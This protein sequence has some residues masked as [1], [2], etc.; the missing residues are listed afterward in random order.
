MFSDYF[1]QLSNQLTDYLRLHPHWITFTFFISG[2]TSGL[3]LIGS[4]LPASVLHFTL[5]VLA[6]KLG[7]SLS[8][9]VVIMLLSVIPGDF[10]GYICGR[11]FKDKIKYCRLFKKRT[12]WF[13]RAE[14]VFQKY[15]GIAIVFG[16]VSGPLR[17]ITPIVS[18]IFNINWSLF[19]LFD[20]FAGLLWCLTHLGLGYIAVNPT[21]WK[22]IQQFCTWF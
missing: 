11:Y 15:G 10:S 7:F 18:G 22:G 1:L 17:A 16:R 6:I 13:E 5:S 8:Y 4:I 9:I 12:I 21:V 14:N 20:F 3:P 19:L 2:I